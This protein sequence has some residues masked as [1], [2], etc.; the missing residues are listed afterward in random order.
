MLPGKSGRGLGD[1]E[2][3]GRKD[4]VFLNTGLGNGF[5]ASDCGENWNL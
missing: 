3:V 1:G 2:V 4:D 5:A